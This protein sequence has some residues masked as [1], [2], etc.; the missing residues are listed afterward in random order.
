MEDIEIFQLFIY[1]LL[2]AGIV[3][4]RELL[5]KDLGEIKKDIAVIKTQINNINNNIVNINF[6]TDFFKIDDKKLE[7]PKG[8]LSIVAEINLEDIEEE[9]EIEEKKEKKSQ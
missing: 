6:P 9:V 1:F 7:Q 3:I 4:L 5:G 8:E 2:L